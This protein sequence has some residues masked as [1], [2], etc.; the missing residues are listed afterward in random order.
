ML[1]CVFSVTQIIKI[2]WKVNIIFRFVDNAKQS[3][4]IVIKIWYNISYK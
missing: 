3:V 1:K 2:T 4:D